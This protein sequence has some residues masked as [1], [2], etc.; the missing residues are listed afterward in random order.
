MATCLLVLCVLGTAAMAQITVSPQNINQESS[1]AAGVASI[2][3]TA[4]G[5]TWNVE[6]VRGIDIVGVDSP[7]IS[8]VTI[9]SPLQQTGNGTINYSFGENPE[10]FPRTARFFFRVT[11][12]STIIAEHRLVQ[13]PS[14]ATVILTPSSINIDGFGGDRTIGVALG[15]LTPWTATTTSAWIQI[16]TGPSVGPG[17][18]MIRILP[19]F[20]G[21][22][23]VGTVTVGSASVTVTQDFTDAT[24]TLGSSS[25]SFPFGGGNGTVAVTA[26]PAGAPWTATSN[27][28]FIVITNGGAYTGTGS[29]TY[30]VASNPNET[31]RQGTI[32]I[33]GQTF[34]VNQ[35]AN[36]GT[37]EGVLTSSVNQLNFVSFPL[38][39]STLERN[40]VISSTGDA[41][42][43][44]VQ[45]NGAPWLTVTPSGGV[46]PTTLVFTANPAG[47]S[48]GNYS[49]TVVVSSP[50]SPSVTI[51][52]S[53]EV[54]ST[55]F[56]SPPLNASPRSL[57]FSRTS[58]GPIPAPQRIRLGNPDAIVAAG[59]QVT[60]NN[61]LAASVNRDENGPGIQVVIRNVTLLPGV[62]DGTIIVR[63]TEAQF[64]EL[65]IPVR[66][67]VQMANAGGPSIFS[68]G[69][70]NAA[71]FRAG[72]APGTWISIFGSGLATST[73]GWNPSTVQG[74]LLPTNLGGTEVFIDGV[75]APLS[76]VSAGQVNALVPG[77]VKRGWVE[78]QVSVNN[79]L[80]PSGYLF[81]RDEDPA[82]F[83]YAPQNGI[84]PAAQHVDG[85]A[86]GPVGLFPGGPP[87]RPANPVSHVVLYGTGFGETAL[88][89]DPATFFKGAA[90]LLNVGDL[91]VRVGPVPAQVT[92]AGL[93]APGLYQINIAVPS[94]TEGDY[95]LNSVL[96][97][98]TTQP[99][100]QLIVR[101]PQP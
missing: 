58:G 91:S 26:N 6:V 82:F 88:A 96:G 83:V 68:G 70:V 35:E 64:A 84:F 24:F 11:G 10:L 33:A 32:T 90:E 44:T 42:S 7:D 12:S 59:I 8:W 48:P 43:F 23:R 80:A 49:G 62:Y 30:S 73:M 95:F 15:P 22:A 77:I 41:L 40:A 52:V 81:L 97:T 63:S 98:L 9:S 3:V 18:L 94:V 1:S 100:L 13:G 76:F 31:A 71:S 47:V 61:W 66:Y 39:T 69:V 72:G 56:T 14:N 53:F 45:I 29:V 25:A 57:Y 51:G 28:P 79:Q 67:V 89:L 4:P 92:F 55:N 38:G 34:T 21:Q 2:A 5:V 74:S 85:T 36:P 17:N 54:R 50:D 19:N 20:T 87:S 78:V 65:E 93:V 16:L 99:G 60:A 46:T 101:R 86:V 37:P 27:D 75:R